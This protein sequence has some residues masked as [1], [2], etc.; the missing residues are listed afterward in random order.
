MTE[1][2]SPSQGRQGQAGKRGVR[3]SINGVQVVPFDAP[4]GARCCG[5]VVDGRMLSVSVGWLRSPVSGRLER[6]TFRYGGSR[7]RL[8]GAAI[9]ERVRCAGRAV[10]WGWAR[11]AG[12]ALEG[13]L[14]G[15]RLARRALLR[16]VR[17]ARLAS[18]RR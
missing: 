9:G 13:L 17:R 1:G 2:A 8:P 11:G 7:D 12:V 6:G 15:T 14:R 16:A 3:R 18:L 5:L 4:T 10:L